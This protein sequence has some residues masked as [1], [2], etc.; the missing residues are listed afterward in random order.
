MLS[1]S[2]VISVS[3]AYLLLLFA[4]AYW[5]D[6]RAAGGRSVI[7]NAWVYGLSM[8]VYCTAWTYFGSVGR[9]AN[10]GVWFLPIYLGPMLAML[11]AW[12]V[13][14]KMIRI[15]K[16]YRITSIADFIA[17]RYGKSPMLA[18]LVTLITVVGIVP[19]IALQL[20]AIAS[21]YAVLTS[22]L[23]QPAVQ[24]ADWW[25]DSTLYVALALAGFTMVFGA[26]HL[27]GTERHEGMVAAIAFESVVKLLAFLAVGLFVSFGLF[28]SPAA[29]FEQAH[30][31]PSLR[32]L[33]QFGQGQPF[34]HAQWLG[35]TLLAML[36]V[37]FLPRQFQ[38]MV[39]ENVDEQHLKRAVWVFPLYL[40]LINLFVLPIA[41]G[42]LLHF[43]A[44]QMD[45]ETFILSLPMSAGHSGLALA[46]FVGG[47]SAATGMV[48]VEAIAVS[49][50]VC[51]D[52]VMP[53]LLRM[54]RFG[55]RSSSDLTG[56][57][58]GIRR[59]AILVVLLLGY[60]YFHLA[61]EAYA[62]VS[63]GL[64]SFAAVA[65]FAPA[66]L[67]GMYWR[68]GTRRGALAGLLAG[69]G[70]WAYM[71]M[72][73][74]L[75]K[76]GWLPDAFLHEGL[77][78][79]DLLRPEA[80]LGLTGLDGL[81][82][83]LFWSML[84]NVGVYV[85]VSLWR[86]PSAAETSQA[87]LFVDV[88]NRTEQ[89]HPVF[90]QGKAQVSALLPLVGR[91]LGPLSAQRLFL[92]YARRHG[93]DRIDA[94][95]ADARLVQFVETQL[96]GAIGSASA[97]VMV[98]SVVEEEPL[99]LDDVMRILDEASQL[100]A[101]SH[102]LE[103]KSRSLERATQ[104]LREANQQLKSLDRM[105]DDFMSSV[106]HELR[107]PLTSIRALTELMRDDVDMETAQRQQF[108][109]IVVGEAERLSRLVNQVLD[110]A[111]IESGQAEWHNTE[112]DLRDILL[113]AVRTMQETYRERGVTLEL[114]MPEVVRPVF[115]D[116]DRLTQVVLNLL[117][118]AVKYAPDERGAVTVR[119]QESAEELVVEVQDNGP[120]IPLEQQ[121]IVF[122]KFRQVEGD[123]HYRPGG[124]GLGLPISRQI[125]EHFG[126]RMW[127]R[128]VPGQGACFAFSLPHP[129]RS[130]M[131]AQNVES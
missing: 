113:Q 10:S 17:S 117:S 130:A 122:E 76:S 55:A 29:L 15:A 37:I 53:L 110:L 83:A 99:D 91:F 2:L 97:R 127:M 78:G 84:A 111:K 20:K 106:T 85:G 94:I 60:L 79:W 39:V 9:A 123:E 11:L 49:T 104:E 3:F 4:V 51:N 90:W 5:G 125:V 61:G 18:G 73:P 74:S 16:T 116:A 69:F 96:A 48:I 19:Y 6:A 124:T 31:V 129:V 38:V 59:L 88:F 23:G 8:A 67:G 56:L 34:A 109:G 102:A 44:G 22:P 98:A 64:I 128:S 75:A 58:L 36:S 77:F 81:T 40:L 14:R 28:D 68:G 24:S 33:L 47:L 80:F 100:R 13:V 42:G 112:L 32:E 115:S 70:F 57:L 62:L 92:D 63:I 120:G 121:A 25:S 87:L 26:R 103:D 46:A 21:G 118:N 119:L 93:V 66:M 1:A 126:G 108:L 12:M 43:G 65:Q 114:K 45:P 89:A 82:H 71:L 41:I 52:L 72:L 107:T 27:D 105:K 54:R 101:Y 131:E 7:G 86:A 30:A 95:P 50:M 35:L